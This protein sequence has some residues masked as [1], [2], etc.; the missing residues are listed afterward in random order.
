LLYRDYF[1]IALPLA[2]PPQTATDESAAF[3]VLEGF[4]FLPL[5]HISSVNFKNS[6]FLKNLHVRVN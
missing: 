1:L 5:Q 2:K 4:D 3:S 6:L